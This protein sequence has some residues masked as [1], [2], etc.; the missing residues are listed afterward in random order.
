VARRTAEAAAQ[1]RADILAAARTL[2]AQNGFAATTTAEV[3]ACA[4]VTVGALFHHFGG[5]VELFGAVF[6]ALDAE[7]NDFAR[8]RAQEVGGVT[9]FLEGYRAFLEFSQHADYHRIVLVESPVVLVGRFQ[10]G[11]DFMRGPANVTQAVEAMIAQGE[12]PPQPAKPL[13]ILLLGAINESAF[14]LARGE[15]GVTISLCVRAMERLLRGH[16]GGT[17]EGPAAGSAC[18]P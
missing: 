2:F 9:G 14:A 12:I 17:Q 8:A 5:K 18:C 6:D 1:T 13:A 11:R 4:G 3:A 10:K 16:A 15:R 7:M